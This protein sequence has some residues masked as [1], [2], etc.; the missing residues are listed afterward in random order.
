LIESLLLDL[1]QNIRQ[2]W[3]TEEKGFEH[4]NVFT[5]PFPQVALDANS[6]AL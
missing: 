5:P 4:L 6:L 2:N 3:L 1:G